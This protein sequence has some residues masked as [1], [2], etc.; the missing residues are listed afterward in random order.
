VISLYTE[1]WLPYTLR[2]QFRVIEERY[3]FGFTLDA[4]GDFIGRGIWTFEQDSK[5]VNVTYD[6]KVQAGKP[7]LRYFSFMMKPV[8]SANHRWAMRKGEESLRLELAR[9]HARS[10]G[11]A[12][13]IPAPPPGD[14]T[15]PVPLALGAVGVLSLFGG[16]L[17]VVSQRQG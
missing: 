1:G 10:P 9:R 5:W 15:S 16:R 14:A 4:W 3:P 6:W 11:R 17:P 13:L 8:F 7:L 2:W 12:C